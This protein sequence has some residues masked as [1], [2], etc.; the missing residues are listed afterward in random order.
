MLSYIHYLFF[1]NFR[2][3]RRIQNDF[4]ALLVDAYF[5]RQK[6]RNRITFLKK[7]PDTCGQD[8]KH[9]LFDSIPQA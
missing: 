4:K 1:K 8:L 7:Y 3:D 5:F 9:E 6:R 2:V